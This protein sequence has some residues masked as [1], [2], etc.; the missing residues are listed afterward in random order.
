MG[1]HFGNLAKIPIS[2]KYFMSNSGF[3]Y[4]LSNPIGSALRLLLILPLL[5]LPSPVFIPQCHGFYFKRS[6]QEIFSKKW[7]CLHPALRHRQRRS[8]PWVLCFR[9]PTPALLQMYFTPI[10]PTHIQGQKV[11]GPGNV[12]T[13]NM[14]PLLLHCASST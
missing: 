6:C 10:P 7:A 11:I 13:G 14:Q 9:R 1:F 5:V 4:L 12:P 2:L 8:L 3:C